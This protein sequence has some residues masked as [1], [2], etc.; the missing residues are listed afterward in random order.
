MG[1]KDTSFG[2]KNQNLLVSMEILNY[3]DMFVETPIYI[4]HFVLTIVIF[5]SMLAI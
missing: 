4:G 2:V 3:K 1:R 5:T